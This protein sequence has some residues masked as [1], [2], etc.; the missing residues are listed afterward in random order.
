M[1][2]GG[3]LTFKG[4]GCFRWIAKD[5]DSNLVDMV[6][7]A[8]GYEVILSFDP[9]CLKAVA[10]ALGRFFLTEEHTDN[11]AWNKTGEIKPDVHFNVEDDKVSI[12][13]EWESVEDW[14]PGLYLS[15]K[16]GKL[17]FYFNVA[18]AKEIEK[19]CKKVQEI[20]QSI[21]D[22]IK[23]KEVESTA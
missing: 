9:A 21:Q 20:R 2:W 3:T 22:V 23:K 14:G 18:Q 1:N 10:D 13:G 6:F 11:P 19:R 8:D 5:K 15:S 12:K 4:K 16:N 7:D 17:G